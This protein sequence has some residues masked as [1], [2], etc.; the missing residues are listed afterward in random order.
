MDFVATEVWATDGCSHATAPS[1]E[2]ALAHIW[3]A[4]SGRN[5]AGSHIPS[6]SVLY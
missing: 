4:W 1:S 2:M 6:L 3:L 5:D